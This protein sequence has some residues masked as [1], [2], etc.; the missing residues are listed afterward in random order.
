[1]SKYYELLVVDRDTSLVRWVEYK[2]YA[3][4]E[5]LLAGCVA[6]DDLNKTGRDRLWGVVCMDAN[7]SVDLKKLKTMSGY[8]EFY[9]D[10]DT[11]SRTCEQEKAGLDGAS[12][13]D[14]QIEKNCEETDWV[15]V[16]VCGAGE[17]CWS[18]EG[19]NAVG[20]FSVGSSLIA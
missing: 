11:K 13:R 18:E 2:D 4:G 3:S 8:N 15:K 14:I 12:A 20:K 1:M 9:T 16:N 17:N 6:I 10:Y 7:V 19:S 5:N